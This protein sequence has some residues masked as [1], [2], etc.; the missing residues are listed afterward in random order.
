MEQVQLRAR[1]GNEGFPDRAEHFIEHDNYSIRK[2]QVVNPEEIIIAG[3][4]MA[5]TSFISGVCF[6]CY[7]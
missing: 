4:F 1:S 7:R 2:I 6:F 3:N 5:I